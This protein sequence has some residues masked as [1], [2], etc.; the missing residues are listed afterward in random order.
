MS[1]RK[2][3]PLAHDLRQSRERGYT[4][5]DGE[6]I[7]GSGV[8]LRRSSGA[9]QRPKSWLQKEVFRNELSRRGQSIV[10]VIEVDTTHR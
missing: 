3:V 6:R 5:D 1:K 10:N 8:G 7:E 4:T 9:A 2:L